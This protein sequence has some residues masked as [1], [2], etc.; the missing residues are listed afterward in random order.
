[1]KRRRSQRWN[2]WKSTDANAKCTNVR[3]LE[4]S[5]ARMGSEWST[6]PNRRRY[7]NMEMGIHSPTQGEGGRE[8]IFE[9]YHAM[10]WMSTW[11]K[12]V[13][14]YVQWSSNLLNTTERVQLK[15]KVDIHYISIIYHTRIYYLQKHN[16][17]L[18]WIFTTNSFL[19]NS[20]F[21]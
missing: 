11:S 2:R 1:M 14:T 6:R 12:M 3:M 21:G 5:N 19:F 18:V 8:K 7:H 15:F 20:L 13:R 4:C 10:Q 9:A 17:K 16:T